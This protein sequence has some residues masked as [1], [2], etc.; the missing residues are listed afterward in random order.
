MQR[1]VR[2]FEAEIVAADVDD[3]GLHACERVGDFHHRAAVAF[4]ELDF[5]FGLGRD[6]LGDFG[7]EEVLHQ[8]DVGVR[9]RM[10]RGDAQ[11]DSLLRHGGGAG[12]GQRYDR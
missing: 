7:H 11:T 8:G 5:V 3:A 10:T 4:D 9:P 2:R 1:Q 12:G 6:P